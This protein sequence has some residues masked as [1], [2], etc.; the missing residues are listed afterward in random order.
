MQVS[1]IPVGRVDIGIE[2]SESEPTV[3]KTQSLGR[4]LNHVGV[5]RV[6]CSRD[7]KRTILSVSLGVSFRF[8]KG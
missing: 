7:A 4:F 8:G 3:E 5:F 2:R 1:C 6:K